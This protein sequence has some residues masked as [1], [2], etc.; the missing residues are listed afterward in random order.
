MPFNLPGT[1]HLHHMDV[2]TVRKE[3]IRIATIPVGGVLDPKEMTLDHLKEIDALR[4]LPLRPTGSRFE[5]ALSGASRGEFHLPLENP[6][7]RPL[8][9][10][11]RL[12]SGDPEWRLQPNHVHGRLEPGA[13]RTFAF[14]YERRAG[15]SL[16]S[17][18]VPYLDVQVDYLAKN[19]RVAL[20]A[21]LSPLPLRLKGLPKGF[22]KAR[23]NLALRLSGREHLRIDA[24]RLPVPDGAFTVEGRLKA[25]TYRGRRGFIA[26]T[27]TS[28]YGI[29]V[30]DGKPTF[31]VFLGTRYVAAEGKR[32]MLKPGRWYHLAGVFDGQEVRMYVDGKLVGRAPGS[33]VR[34]QRSLPLIIGA[35]VD[36]LERPVSFTPGLVDEI[37][38]SKGA[39]YTGEAFEPTLRHDPD[40]DTL[41]LLH[42]D[43][44]VGSF[45]VDHSPAAAHVSTGRELRFLPTGDDAADR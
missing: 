33:G 6:V 23:P 29:F 16:D 31:S 41:L 35:D 4:V 2:V 45:V 13:K 10:T 17:L 24:D 44:G 40:D 27:E 42:L 34:R 19:I 14:R 38:I 21:R 11:I 36:G 3:G 7:G 22:F 8:E 5:V 37:R 1:G 26:K 39:R 12:A 20:P 28:D 18:R 25:D 43:G 15:A 30:S 32:G 9:V